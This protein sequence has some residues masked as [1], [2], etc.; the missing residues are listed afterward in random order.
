[1]RK[2]LLVIIVLSLAFVS[3]DDSDP[4]PVF[5]P[6]LLT[7]ATVDLY[8]SLK[9]QDREHWGEL[10]IQYDENNKID[11]ATLK[12]WK[13]YT[14][15]PIYDDK[16]EMI[17]IE[18]PNDDIIEV[19]ELL[20]GALNFTET[21]TDIEYD[22][23]GNPSKVTAEYTVINAGE[24]ETTTVT[25]EFTYD[26]K[27]FFLYGTIEAAGLLN[28]ISAPLSSSMPEDAVVDKLDRL[29]PLNNPTSVIIKINGDKYVEAYIDYTYNADQHPSQG[30]MEV[31]TWHHDSDND[32]WSSETILAKINAEYK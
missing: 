5:T 22:D 2:L 25:V 12:T 6:K 14:I 4:K 19:P 31:I 18:L 16:G 15:N 11:L 30:E 28:V 29:M 26:D 10:N 7:K 21:F 24:T 32:E 23:A 27:P 17:K 8:G 1:M 20:T 3:C 9:V 13:E